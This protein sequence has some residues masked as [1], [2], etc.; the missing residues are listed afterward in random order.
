[1]LT[2]LSSAS[3]PAL[4]LP[5]PPCLLPPPLLP[6]HLLLSLPPLFLPSLHPSFSNGLSM[7]VKA[8]CF[9]AVGD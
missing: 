1:M 8:V 5:L 2:L 9:G 3:A 6:L 7:V 4:L